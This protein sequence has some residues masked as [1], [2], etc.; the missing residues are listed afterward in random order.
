MG[1]WDRLASNVL[2]GGYV[3]CR[4]DGCSLARPHAADA[5]QLHVYG[6]AGVVQGGRLQ[7]DARRAH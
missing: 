1:G 6:G 2:A 7:D 5:G 4:L 3:G